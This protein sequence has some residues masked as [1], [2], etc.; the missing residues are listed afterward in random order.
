MC[1][2][3]WHHQKEKE[4]G[5]EKEIV[6]GSQRKYLTPPQVMAMALP[7]CHHVT[8]AFLAPA[9]ADDL[10]APL[11]GSLL[12]ECTQSALFGC[13]KAYSRTVASP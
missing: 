3:R 8:I 5:N 12:R 13:R 6:M 4:K 1:F 7:Q 9:P 10:G 11:T 2:G